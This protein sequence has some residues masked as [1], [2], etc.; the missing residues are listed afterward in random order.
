MREEE[1]AWRLEIHPGRRLDYEGVSYFYEGGA[2]PDKP[3]AA[4]NHW[5][6][7]E[8]GVDFGYE[9]VLRSPVQENRNIH[10]VQ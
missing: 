7:S 4:F 1:G 9:L 3:L 8:G 2:Y 6:N 5:M 10:P